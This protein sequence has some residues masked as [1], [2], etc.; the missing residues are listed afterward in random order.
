MIKGLYLVFHFIDP[1]K[2]GKPFIHDH[3]REFKPFKDEFELYDYADQVKN[4]D[5]C[6]NW[7]FH[8]IE[9]FNG[10]KKLWE[11]IIHEH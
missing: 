8:K 4:E 7:I 6:Y 11:V 5:E 9:G 3:N 10:K 2:Y 1:E